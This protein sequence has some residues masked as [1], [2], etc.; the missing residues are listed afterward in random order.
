MFYSPRFIIKAKTQVVSEQEIFGKQILT[1]AWK[2]QAV[3]KRQLGNEV[4]R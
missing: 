4:R 3:G 1:G 2:F